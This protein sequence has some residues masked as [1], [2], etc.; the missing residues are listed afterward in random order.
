MHVDPTQRYSSAE[1]MEVD[2]QRFLDRRPVL[3]QHDT[4]AYRLRKLHVRKPWL[5]PVA[6]TAM[7]VTVGFVVT[8][9]NYNNQLRI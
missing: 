2:L 5:I 3:A 7:I 1:E 8:L 9:L 4:F 6:L